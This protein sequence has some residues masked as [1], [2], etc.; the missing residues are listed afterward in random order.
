VPNHRK[1]II[2]KHTKSTIL[3]LTFYMHQNVYLHL[4]ILFL[5]NLMISMA[6]F[7]IFNV[8]DPNMF[9][10]DIMTVSILAFNITWVEHVFR[11]LL[12]LKAYATLSRTFGFS[13]IILIF[14]TAS[15]SVLSSSK[16]LINSVEP[17]MIYAIILVFIRFYMRGVW[18]RFVRK[19]ARSAQ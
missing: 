11:L 16:P 2:I 1:K 18:I 10:I 8:L 4:I 9:L 12:P 3:R 15:V 19:K 6:I 5:M 14:I 13:T 17:L 7:G